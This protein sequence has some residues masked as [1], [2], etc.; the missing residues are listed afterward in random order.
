VVSSAIALAGLAATHLGAQ[1][2]IARRSRLRWWMHQFLFWG[3][4]LAAA[5]TFPLVFGW[6]H[7][8]SRAGDQ[9]TYVTYIFGFPVLSF[10]IRTV[11][12]WFLFHGLDIAA[13]L[14]LGGIALALWRRMRDRGAQALQIFARDFLPLIILFAI[15]VTGLALTASSLWMRGAFYDFLA[16]L[17]AVT[18]VAAL[19][20]LPFGKFFHVFQRPAQLG[21]KLYHRAGDEGEGARCARCGERFASRM[22]VDDLKEILPRLGF[23]YAI[24][25]PAGNWQELCP[26][27]K[28]KSLAMAQLRLKEETGG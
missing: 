25:G 5:I 26:P 12:S 8:G 16:I 20:Y 1:T 9:M 28:R 15:S 17:H 27:C 6:I 23:D 13:I 7:F 18:V 19:L 10:P 11:V 2:F 4:V 3:C 24:A 21:V 22:H 14:V